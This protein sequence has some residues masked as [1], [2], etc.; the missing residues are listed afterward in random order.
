MLCG[1]SNS[2][3]LHSKYKK[4]LLNHEIKTFLS[5]TGFLLSTKKPTKY[6]RHTVKRW[7]VF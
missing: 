1:I 6:P 2:I 7:I 3:A 4:E 5:K